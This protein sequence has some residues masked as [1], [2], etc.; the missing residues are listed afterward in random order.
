[1]LSDSNYPGDQETRISVSGFIL[2]LN[3]SCYLLEIKR[4]EKQY[5]LVIGNW[6]CC[7]NSGIDED[8]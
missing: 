8:S 5:A 6:V 3:G 1:M 4:T 7:F 2:Y